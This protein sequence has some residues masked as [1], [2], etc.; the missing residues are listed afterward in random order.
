MGLRDNDVDL[1]RWLFTIRHHEASQ[2]GD[3]LRLASLI[4][5]LDKADSSRLVA[6][7]ALVDSGALRVG[8]VLLEEVEQVVVGVGEWQVRHVH[9]GR[10]EHRLSWLARLALASRTG[11]SIVLVLVSGVVLEGVVLEGVVLEIL[12]RIW[13]AVVISSV[14][15]AGVTVV[16]RTIGV[17]IIAT[18][19]LVLEGVVLV[20]EVV[21][22]RVVV[23]LLELAA[24]VV[25]V[26][27]LAIVVVL[28]SIAATLAILTLTI[29]ALAILSLVR[30]VVVVLAWRTLLT[31]SRDLDLDFL[32]QNLESLVLVQGVVEV[33]SIGEVDE[34]VSQWT[35]T[36]GNHLSDSEFTP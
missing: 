36:T 34:A 30:A 15:T 28:A 23:L 13:E 21:E 11:W 12:S 2:L 18:K 16:S 9:S 20:L 27:G 32:A 6:L 31:R 25:E 26:L 35:T 33:V 7:L 14:V 3:G 8:R 17:L 29:L 5:V 19:V 24:I 4:L 1:S 22:A 10:G